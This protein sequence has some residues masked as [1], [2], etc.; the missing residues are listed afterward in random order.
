VDIIKKPAKCALLFW[1]YLRAEAI[2]RGL[3]CS[4]IS[5]MQ[6]DVEESFT[7]PHP[8]RWQAYLCR[9]GA[10]AKGKAEPGLSHAGGTSYGAAAAAVIAAALFGLAHVPGG[11][12]LVLLSGVAAIGYGV[13]Y[14]YGGMLAAVGAHFGLFTYPMLAR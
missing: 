8:R 3:F 6:A 7:S 2:Q 12:E 4:V 9:V 10:L 5:F 13:A 11:R 1:E 14:R